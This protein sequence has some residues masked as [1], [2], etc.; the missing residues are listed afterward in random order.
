MCLRAEFPLLEHL[1]ELVQ[2]AVVKV[3][4]LILALPAGHHQLATRASFITRGPQGG[5]GMS[6]LTRVLISEFNENS[7]LGQETVSPKGVWL[8]V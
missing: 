8:P 3:K 7:H 4:N 1:G 2:A 6:A 5:G